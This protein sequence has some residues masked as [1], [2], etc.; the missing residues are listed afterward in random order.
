V[1]LANASMLAPLTSRAVAAAAVV[2]TVTASPSA[3]AAALGAGAAVGAPRAVL[4]DGHGDEGRHATKRQATGGAGGTPSPFS[5][6]E[7][8]VSG[9]W[10]AL[11]LALPPLPLL[12]DIPDDKELKPRPRQTFFNIIFMYGHRRVSTTLHAVPWTLEGRCVRRHQCSLSGI[13][14]KGFR[15]LEHRLDGASA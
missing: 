5:R 7:R 12:A 15:R 11:A 9:A 2:G 10:A 8:A 14:V 6:L 3:A 4:A 13:N 1:A